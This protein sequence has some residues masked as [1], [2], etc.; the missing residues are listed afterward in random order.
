MYWHILY[1]NIVYHHKPLYT[2]INRDIP[3]YTINLY[4]L[5]ILSWKS[6][7]CIYKYMDR[8]L[9]SW[10]HAL[11]WDIP[12]QVVISCSMVYQPIYTWYTSVYKYDHS[13]PWCED[14]RCTICSA[15]TMSYVPW[16]H[17]RYS[18][19]FWTYDI[20]YNMF[21]LWPTMSYVR[22]TMSYDKILYR[23]NLRC[24][25]YDVLTSKLRGHYVKLCHLGT[26]IHIMS[27]LFPI[28][29]QLFLLFYLQFLDYYVKLFHNLE[30][31]NYFNYVNTINLIMS[32]PIYYLYY[33]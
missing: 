10:Y 27:Q 12:F 33:H 28:V 11:K 24:Q 30:M 15:P 3:W 32:N 9:K 5:D 20:V 6:Y 22:N 26:I 19:Y 21:S 4:I 18:M 1:L 25:T 13:H 14:S 29:S 17:L 7:T 2:V 16:N 23:Q 8:Y 31:N